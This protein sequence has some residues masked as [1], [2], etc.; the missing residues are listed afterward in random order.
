MLINTTYVFNIKELRINYPVT[1]VNK[2]Q[3]PSDLG[4]SEFLGQ[5]WRAIVS[6]R[7]LG[8]ASCTFRYR[9]KTYTPQT[10]G[11]IRLPIK[12]TELPT[13]GSLKLSCHSCNSFRKVRSIW[14]QQE[15][16]SDDGS[17]TSWSYSSMG[18]QAVPAP[19]T[20]HTW[21]LHVIR[22]TWLWRFLK[23]WWTP[24][25]SRMA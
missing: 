22:H 1:C 18:N 10:Q 8:W 19:S 16:V 24:T 2:Y 4:R 14:R 12:L 3:S 21:R 13:P 15:D 25:V 11:R 23:F 20:P 17:P 5:V 9:W 7:R 6:S